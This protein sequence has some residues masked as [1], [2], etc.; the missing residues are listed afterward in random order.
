METILNHMVDCK[1]KLNYIKYTCI[2]GGDNLYTNIATASILSKVHRD[3]YIEDM[4]EKYPLLDEYY[5]LDQTK[6]MEH[7]N[8]LWRYI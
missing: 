2:E 7:Q 8:I 3:E 6:V 1:N 5:D 4:C